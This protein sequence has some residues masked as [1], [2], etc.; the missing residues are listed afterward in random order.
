FAVWRHALPI[1]EATGNIGNEGVHVVVQVRRQIEITAVGRPAPRR[2]LVIVLRE[3]TDLV[4]GAGRRTLRRRAGCS[5]LSDGPGCGRP[6]SQRDG[7]R[8][9]ADGGDTCSLRDVRRHRDSS[10]VDRYA[11]KETR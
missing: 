4:G 9:G 7:E 11:A 6:G 3:E 8:T 1:D 2:A 5:S 10:F